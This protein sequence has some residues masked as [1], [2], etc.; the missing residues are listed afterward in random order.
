MKKKYA[1]KQPGDTALETQAGVGA[2]ST[3]GSHEFSQ[4][5]KKRK[6]IT[7]EYVWNKKRSVAIKRAL[8]QP[9]SSRKCRNHKVHFYIECV[10]TSKFGYAT[11]SFVSQLVIILQI[12]LTFPP[13]R[14]HNRHL[15]YQGKA[16]QVQ[17]KNGSIYIQRSS[18]FTCRERA[19]PTGQSQLWP[20]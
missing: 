9:Y 11:A 20:I 7:L 12:G 5:K 17:Q 19:H 16:T 6:Q 2:S 8:S 10:W 14:S 18:F 4:N 13:R 1:P 3:L 15:N